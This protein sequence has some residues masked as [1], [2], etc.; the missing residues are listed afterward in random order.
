MINIK[1]NKILSPTAHNKKKNGG[2]WVAKNGIV[3]DL[4]DEAF[5]GGICLDLPKLIK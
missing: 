1:K 4:T 3:I 2:L 5:S